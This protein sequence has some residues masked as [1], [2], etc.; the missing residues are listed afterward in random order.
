MHDSSNESRKRVMTKRDNSKFWLSRSRENEG[1]VNVSLLSMT[2]LLSLLLNYNYNMYLILTLMY[3]SIYGGR[4]RNNLQEEFLMSTSL[5]IKTFIYNTINAQIG[6]YWLVLC[7]LDTAG[8]ITE[9]GASVEEMP[10]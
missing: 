8:V 6:V 10:P 2:L 7:Q 4:A 3:S 5:K 9:K 1:Y